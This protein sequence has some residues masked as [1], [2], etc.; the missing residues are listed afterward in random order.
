M[1][2]GKPQ[3]D[4]DFAEKLRGAVVL[5]GIT[6][7][8]STGETQEQ[9]YGTVERADA[10]GIDIRLA[11]SRAGETFF[12]P[13]DPRAFFPAQPGSYRLRE[14]GEVIENPDYTTTWTIG[15]DED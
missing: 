14:T 10:E 4:E 2:D 7:M 8:A 12:L 6:R 3:W 5:V 1:D 15:P 11:G 9:F 13:P